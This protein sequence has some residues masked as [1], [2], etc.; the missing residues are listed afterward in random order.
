MSDP[1]ENDSP[2]DT[3]FGDI[4]LG[5]I[6]FGDINRNYDDNQPVFGDI[7]L[8]LDFDED[9]DGLID[10]FEKDDEVVGVNSDGSDVNLNLQN[11]DYGLLSTD[12]IEPAPAAELEPVALSDDFY[13]IEGVG[14]FFLPT[15]SSEEISELGIKKNFDE[16]RAAFAYAMKLPDPDPAAGWDREFSK[17][18]IDFRINQM[19]LDPKFAS[20]NE[21]SDPF[22]DEFFNV[23][24]RL[25]DER[26]EQDKIANPDTWSIPEND[27]QAQSQLTGMRI[28]L[29]EYSGQKFTEAQLYSRSG[30][31]T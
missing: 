10:T 11:A 2:V 29:Q 28:L 17:Q 30:T 16:I 26:V 14:E 24:G 12:G 20:F 22:T 7:D 27:K 21:D 15:V 8:D 25:F 19:G 13:T 1:K 5:D 23:L 4:D 31:K 9:D 6:D 18:L 3:D